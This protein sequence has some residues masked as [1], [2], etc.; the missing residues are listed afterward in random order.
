MIIFSLSMALFDS[1]STTQQIIIFVLLLTTAKPLQ[2]ALSY[3][4][5]LIGAYIVG[6]IAG[7][8]GLDQLLGF[9][10]KYIPS[11]RNVSDPS[12]YLSELIAGIVMVAIGIWYFHKKR[13]AQ[14]G[15][16][17]NMILA[18]LRSMNSSFAFGIGVFI[19]VTS[20]PFS[21]PYIV[22]LGKY[23]SLHLNLPSAIG[24][25]L[26]YNI[27]YALPMI[28]V[29]IMYLFARSGTDDLKDTLHEKARILNVQLTTW[30]LAGVGIFS[31][32]DAGFYISTG[33][34]LVKGRCF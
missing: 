20:F 33:H 30:A 9:V 13:H 8:I 21:I 32:I 29:L 22:A 28:V 23:T 7:F 10:S 26:V 19:S 25:I 3:L 18:K 14:P 11:M 2:N 16:T 34:A 15:K 5:G 12:Y 17:Q 24:C 31:M 4:F 6:G 27:G 1:L